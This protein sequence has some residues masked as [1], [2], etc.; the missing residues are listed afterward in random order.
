MR[1][2]PGAEG[3]PGKRKVAEGRYGFPYSS[4]MIIGKMFCLFS[5]IFDK[6]NRLI[7][8]LEEISDKNISD[9][10]NY[11]ALKPNSDASL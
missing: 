4:S 6:V 10:G 11:E 3:D 5:V 1:S 9:L 2:L 8:D 7:K